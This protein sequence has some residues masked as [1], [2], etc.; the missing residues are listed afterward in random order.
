LRVAATALALWCTPFAAVGQDA[1]QTGSREGAAPAAAPATPKNTAAAPADRAGSSAAASA[2]KAGMVSDPADLEAFFDGAINV[3]LESKHVAG[4]VVA[5]VVGD[6]VVFSKG[7]G[8]ADVDARR[9]VD[10]EKTLFRIA[11]ISK[12]FTWTAVMQ[13]IEEGKL[14]L[15]TDVNTY[16]KELKI[17]ATFEQ[18]ITLRHLLTHT[19]GFED[20]V[21]GLFGRE[22][23]SRALADVLRAQLPLRVR[24]P[25]VLSSYSNHGTALAG[26]AVAC[27]SGIPWEDYV[28]K[29][30]LTP[31]GMAH[32]LVRQ[33]AE[34]D[35]PADLSTGY[36]W[37]KG[38]FEAKP[39]EYVPAAPAGCMSTTAADIA[40]FMI[41]H[42]NDGRYGEAR[43]LKPET[44]RR[45]REP[46]FRHDPK[47]SAMCYGFIEDQRGGRR[48]VGHGGDTIW[49]HSMLQL[50]PDEHVGLFVSYNTDTSAAGSRDELFEAFLKRYFPAPEPPKITPSAEAHGRLK[51]LAGEYVMDRYSHSS[52]TKL[53]ALMGVFEVSPNDD[54]TLTISIGNQ[55]RRYAEVEP[56]VFREVDGTRTFV[57]KEGKDG[58]GLYLFP[59]NMP[60]L[61]GE[62]P[63]W[64]ESSTTNLI[65]AGASIGIFATAVLFWPAIAFSV[66]GLSSPRITRNWRSG[67]L[68]CLG[69]MT[70]VAAIG[71]ACAVAYV[72]KDPNDIVFG[73]TPAMKGLLAAAPLLA[74]LAAVTLLASL[75]AWWRRYWRFAGRLHYTLVALAGVGFTLFLYNWNLLVIGV[76][77][78]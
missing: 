37:E 76:G 69:W 28:E 11:S 68:S 31:L 71:F 38:R 65:V 48:F 73:L 62:R 75:V 10:P 22:P 54:D 17:P 59:G 44:A 33:P 25:G 40:R 39:F 35:L 24:P 2:L 36:K 43:I 15:D 74:G 61:A 20:Y 66:R 77:G 64:Y 67:V 19:P 21:V 23:D 30:I 72:L 42:L 52:V 51:R 32:T 12:L 7:Y 50:A 26:Y 14:D 49:F 78:K 34:A 6:R 45:M 9:K 57:F 46:L 55:S 5:V 13:Q 41:A 27:V 3:Q 4:A 60:P 16:L 63:R 47:T 70:S 56:L 8:Y 53:A 58:R 29:R 1:A 18:P